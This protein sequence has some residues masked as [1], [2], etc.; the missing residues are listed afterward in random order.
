M[1]LD[2]E[3]LAIKVIENHLKS[4]PQY[5]IVAKY[6]NAVDAFNYLGNN[7]VDV[8]FLDINMPQL[9]GIDMI[10]NLSDPPLLVF[11]TAHEEYALESFNYN[12]IDYLVKPISLPRFMKTVQ[13]INNLLHIGLHSDHATAENDASNN[14]EFLFIKVDKKMIKVPLKDILYIE[15]LKDYVRIYINGNSYITHLN[16]NKIMQI[17][18]ENQFLRIHRSFVISLLKIEAIDGNCVQIDKK[19]IPIGRNYVKEVKP[20]ILNMGIYK[21]E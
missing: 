10:K 19:L 5:Q 17:L 7:K 4:L 13:K 21:P 15:S 6:E 9:N 18:P 3:P 8:L 20:T 1:I 14:E 11:T 12:V 16:L 2:D